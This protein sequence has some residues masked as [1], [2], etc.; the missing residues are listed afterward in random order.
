[1]PV[2][3]EQ[4]TEKVH[5]LEGRYDGIVDNVKELKSMMQRLLEKSEKDK[6]EIK[7]EIQQ[8]YIKT[9]QDKTTLIKWMV[10]LLLGFSALIIT[11]MSVILHY[12]LN[13]V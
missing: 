11:V 12:A 2:T 9:E 10:G 8:L 6:S 3:I 5:H 1:M 7:N 13:G 4:L